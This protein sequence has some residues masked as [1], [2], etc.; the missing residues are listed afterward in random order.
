M[1]NSIQIPECMV[2]GLRKRALE[3]KEKEERR[4]ALDHLTNDDIIAH[5]D[6]F[7]E[8]LE[9]R[10]GNPSIPKCMQ[11]FPEIGEKYPALLR[12]IKDNPHEFKVGGKMRKQLDYM[13]GMRQRLIDHDIDRTSAEEQISTK[14]LRETGFKG[15]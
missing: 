5:V 9:S 10:K 8:W 7:I 4:Q 13:L 2:D 6:R 3:E 11:K 14:F 1:S 12:S 15:I